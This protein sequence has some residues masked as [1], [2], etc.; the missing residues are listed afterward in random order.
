MYD[1]I[2]YLIAQGW[3]P[4][5]DTSIPSHSFGSLLT[6]WKLP[7]SASGTWKRGGRSWMTHVTAPIPITT[8]ACQLRQLHAPEYCQPLT[9]RGVRRDAYLGPARQEGYDGALGVG[10]K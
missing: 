3:T 6:M 5:S 4:A 9:E 7:C 1:Q 10:S 2:A 8:Y